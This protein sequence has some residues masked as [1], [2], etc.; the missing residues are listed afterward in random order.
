M[1]KTLG[2]TGIGRGTGL[3]HTF[4]F[5]QPSQKQDNLLLILPPHL[6]FC[7][8]RIL[9]TL[10]GYFTPNRKYYAYNLLC[11]LDYPGENYLDRD[12]GLLYFYPPSHIAKGE[13]WV[14][15]SQTVISAENI[16]YISFEGIDI[17]YSRRNGIDI[18]NAKNI[19]ISNSVIANHGQFSVN[20]TNFI[21]SIMTKCEIFSPGDS[22]LYLSGRN[23]NLELVVTIYRWW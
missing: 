18:A 9:L 12:A 6:V 3:I 17:M 2:F 15:I 14:S 21:N 11:E 5:N 13:T 19:S 22:G 8:T 4:T 7:H 20:L 10:L 16:A 1:R 23:G